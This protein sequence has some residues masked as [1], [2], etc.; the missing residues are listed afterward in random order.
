MAL[1]SNDAFTEKTRKRQSKAG[2]RFFCPFKNFRLNRQN[3]YQAKRQKAAAAK[4][5]D[6][7]KDSIIITW[8]EKKLF[9]K[10]TCLTLKSFQNEWGH[11]KIF[12][13]WLKTARKWRSLDEPFSFM[14]WATF[15][16]N[17][18]HLYILSTVFENQPKS[19]TC[20]EFRT[21]KNGKA[22]QFVV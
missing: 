2:L 15:Q 6:A 16:L 22:F 3:L 14:T 18:Y 1:C 21:E 17:R 20:V 12:P 9:F 8:L 13:S 7:E 11:P 19:R 10:S 4:R 5:V